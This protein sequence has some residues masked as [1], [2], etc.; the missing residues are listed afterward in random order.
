MMSERLHYNNNLSTI[1]STKDHCILI[2]FIYGFDILLTISID[3]DTLLT[4]SGLLWSGLFKIYITTYLFL[5]L[6]LFNGHNIC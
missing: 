3:T 5:C 2:A 6:R 4:A 1:V